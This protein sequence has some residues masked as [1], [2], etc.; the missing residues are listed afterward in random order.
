MTRPPIPDAAL[1]KHIA[2]LGMNGSGKTSVAKAVIIEPALRAGV[3][4]RVFC[5]SLA[6]IFDAE[7][8]DAWRDEVMELVAETPMLDWLLLT[9][10]PNVAL[11][12]WEPRALPDNVWMG[13]TVEDQPAA[14]ARIPIL[15]SIEARVRFIS[16]EPALGELFTPR[17]GIHWIIC[18]GESGP[19]A[20]PMDMAWATKTREDC[21]RHGIA[22]FMKQL[23]GTRD[24]RDRI[25]DFP[26]HLRV[27]EFPLQRIGERG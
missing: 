13:V 11:K 16:Y 15:L 1:K 6:D 23:G 5:A 10:R 27:R 14:E 18:G 21:A 24:K 9:K 26:A 7:V 22:F 4:R 25:E 17:Y 8:S 3:R 12:Y 20:R 2:I 19:G